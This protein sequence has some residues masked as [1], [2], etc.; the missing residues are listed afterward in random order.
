MQKGQRDDASSTWAAGTSG[1][2]RPGWRRSRCAPS[3]PPAPP[4]LC[5]AGSRA[6]TRATD[7]SRSTGASL[8]FVLSAATRKKKTV[9]LL[10]LIEE[11]IL[12][13]LTIEKDAYKMK[14]GKGRG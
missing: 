14:S 6:D 5:Y 2:P 7:T 4:G 12:N 1:R 13:L 10:Y 9:N 8:P 11:K 3:P